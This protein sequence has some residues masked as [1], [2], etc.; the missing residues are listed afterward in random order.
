MDQGAHLN[1]NVDFNPSAT[2]HC[3][4]NF[5]QRECEGVELIT[6]S[7]DS[8]KHSTDVIKFNQ[9]DNKG[10]YL[11][12]VSVDHGKYM[13]NSSNNSTNSTLP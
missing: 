13:T 7:V 4:V 11:V 12:H 8:D 6:A 9:I 10:M 3:R 2:I 1:L 5:A